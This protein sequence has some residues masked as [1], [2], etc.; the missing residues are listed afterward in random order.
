MADSST[1]AAGAVVAGDEQI[2][3]RFARGGIT[4]QSASC[5]ISSSARTTI[6][7]PSCST[8]WRR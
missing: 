3:R 4:S 8:C 6:P 2:L 1:P 7:S 5:A